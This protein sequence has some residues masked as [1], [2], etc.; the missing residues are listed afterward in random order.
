MNIPAYA[1]SAHAATNKTIH[2]PIDFQVP[3][4]CG[5]VSVYPGD[6]LVGDAEGVVVIPRRLVAE[7]AAQAAAQE[8]CE[9]FILK[10]IEGGAPLLGTY[11]PDDQTLAEYQEYSK[12]HPKPQA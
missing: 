10:K 12:T 7:V 6:I 9:D 1:R 8:H 5:G 2:H 4:G 3:I 11:P